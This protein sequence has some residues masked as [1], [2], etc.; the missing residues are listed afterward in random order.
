MTVM[1]S[2]ELLWIIWRF[3]KELIS[4]AS[5]IPPNAIGGAYIKKVFN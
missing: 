5:S 4:F 1:Q 3:P 2:V